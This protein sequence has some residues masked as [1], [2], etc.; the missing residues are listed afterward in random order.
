MG[1]ERT[2]AKPE[3]WHFDAPDATAA[4]FQRR[5]FVRYLRTHGGH[6]DPYGDAELIFGELVG[7]VVLHAPGPIEVFVDWPDGRATLYVTDEGQQI[8][9]YRSVPADPF[10]ERGRG[11]TIVEKLSYMVTA[12]VYPGFGKMIRAAL[13]V[14]RPSGKLIPSSGWNL[15]AR[16]FR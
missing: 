8:D 10:A 9:L 1:A 3:R 5:E 4:L 16:R 13:P 14:R 12:A 6:A 15:A 7:N 2:E 11:L